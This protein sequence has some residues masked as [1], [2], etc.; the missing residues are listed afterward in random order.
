MNKHIAS[1]DILESFEKLSKDFLELSLSSEVSLVE[2]LPTPLEFLKKWVMPNV[3]VLFR[4]A[5]RHW[6]ALK[7]WTNQYLRDKIGQKEVTVAVTP[8]G[9]GDAVCDGY[10]VMPEERKMTMNSFI[11]ILEGHGQDNYVY[12]I[13]KQNSNLT[14][15]FEELVS[16][17][18]MELSW[19]T[20]AFGVEPDAV[21]FWMGDK[22]AVTSMHKDHYE[23]IYCVVRGQKDFILIPPTDLPWVPYENFQAAVYKTSEDGQFH[24]EKDESFGIVPWIP[25][26][27]EQP[28]YQC[29]PKFQR[30]TKLWCSVQ[31][32]DA[33]Y[34]PS[35]WFHH[36][37]QSHGCIA[38]NF[39]YDMDFDVKYAYFKFLERLSNVV[40]PSEPAS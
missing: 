28:D 3:P 20:S 6:P 10:F 7:K 5:V 39:W 12:Y 40:F 13:Q 11:N 37:R 33:L 35:L 36:V 17:V 31:E 29:Y 25:V 27:P 26:D 22:R 30:A 38:V 15:E 14:E 19:A 21:N 32:G 18:A 9:Y 16:D 23:N 8:T 1:K 34:L 2:S 24:I 4:Q